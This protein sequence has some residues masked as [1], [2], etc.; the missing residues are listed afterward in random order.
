[1]MAPNC[2]CAD[3]TVAGR[4]CIVLGDA[5]ESLRAARTH[6]GGTGAGGGTDAAGGTHGAGCGVEREGG[7][8]CCVNVM[9]YVPAHVGAVMVALPFMTASDVKSRTIAIWP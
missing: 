8:H 5:G 1:M 2:L 3:G 6:Q 9:S 4:A 7:P